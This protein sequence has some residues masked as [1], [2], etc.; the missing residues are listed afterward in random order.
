M[1]R[2]AITV[3][4]HGSLFVGGYTHAQGD[5][6]GDT[7]T[8]TRGLL[9]P[10][11]AIKGALRES[12]TRLVNAVER[13]EDLLIQLFGDEKDKPGVIRFG[14]LHANETSEEDTSRHLTSRHHVS[15]ERATR[16]ASPG[17]LFQNR[18]TPAG[19]DLPFRG[20]IHATRLLSD[21]ELGLL[22][23][24]VAIT[25]QIGGGRGRGLGYISVELAVDPAPVTAEPVL[26]AG[27][28]T[29]TLVLE[30]QEPLQLGAVKD[31]T[32]VSST[33]GYI[34]G[35]AVRGAVAATLAN[36]DRSQLETVLGGTSPATFGDAH[37]GHLSA[38]PAPMTLREP[39]GSGRLI[40]EAADLCAGATARH[41]DY[42]PAKGTFAQTVDHD[43]QEAADEGSGWVAV[44]LQQRIVTRTARDHKV[45][46]AADGLLFSLEVI[47]PVLR[48]GT[49]T[50]A[51]RFYAPITGTAEQLHWIARAAAEGLL[52]GGTRSRGFGR[53]TLDGFEHDSGLPRL[54]QRHQRWV[55][56]VEAHGGSN[57]I[58]TGVLLALGPIAVDQARLEATLADRGFELVGGVSRRRPHGGWNSKVHLPRGVSSQFQPGSTFIVRTHDGSS[59]L[60]SLRELESNGIGPGR[61]D[62]WGRIIACHPIYVDCCKEN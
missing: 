51:L 37:P 47:D 39:K 53:L 5:S 16:Q 28:S 23:S 58:A 18:V 45:G 38:I 1:T 8:D 61:P 55:S 24:A 42:R 25:D 41:F 30:A 60:S 62:G 3:K 49:A 32:N 15:L 2:F 20:E 40:D 46:R 19:H 33:K 13:G 59:A 7:A 34:D 9:V 17:R 54:E 31:P 6:D 48:C 29:M 10:G 27:I 56:T 21:E 35:S 12:A 4:P 11:S 14:P 57:G 22:Q 44:S 26:P 43:N 36:L 52:V 50:E